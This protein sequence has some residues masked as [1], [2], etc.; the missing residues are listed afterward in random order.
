MVLFS[1]FLFV[2]TYSYNIEISSDSARENSDKENSSEENSNEE[3][4]DKENFDEDNERLQKEARE[5]Y[6]NSFWYK[7]LFNVLSFCFA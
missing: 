3:N 6:Q 2:Q 4:T 7:R 5:R 1:S